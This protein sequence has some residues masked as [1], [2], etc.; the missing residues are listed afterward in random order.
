MAFLQTPT[1]YK[2]HKSQLPAFSQG[3]RTLNTSFLY[4][5]VFTGCLLI[6]ALSTRYWSRCTSHSMMTPSQ[7]MCGTSA[8]VYPKQVAT[9][10]WLTPAVHPHV[11]QHVWGQ[12]IRCVPVAWD[13]LRRGLQSAISVT[14]LKKGLLTHLFKA[15]FSIACMKR[16]AGI[17]YMLML[18]IIVNY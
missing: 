16:I 1:V 11:P 4:L 7:C 3:P 13:A 8:G 18:G 6:N 10:R 2:S 5:G 17:H 14:S 15:V 9:F 12:G